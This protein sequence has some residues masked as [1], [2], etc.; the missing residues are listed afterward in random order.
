ML[1]AACGG[2]GTSE[3]HATDGGAD[4]VHVGSHCPC[5]SG[6]YCDLS[7]NT[8]KAGCG[9][10]DDC[11]STQ[12]CN[13]SHQCQNGCR[14]VSGCPTVECQTAA[15]T[16]GACVY[17]NVPDQTHCSSDGNPCSFDDCKAGACTHP[18]VPD[19]WPCYPSGDELAHACLAGTC[20]AS[21]ETCT[22][23]T[24]NNLAIVYA[25]PSGTEG[26][27]GTSCSCN[28]T[29][30]NL[31]GTTNTYACTAC[32]VDNYGGGYYYVYCL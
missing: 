26:P 5:A 9:T 15:C 21:T 22:G 17:A 25:E 16:N 6:S 28:G 14:D 20:R 10:N 32:G 23:S 3:H 12:I 19:Y 11:P 30:M 1:A 27:E 18:L 31:N 13:A 2:G 29:T 4:A 7:D 8:C 24:T